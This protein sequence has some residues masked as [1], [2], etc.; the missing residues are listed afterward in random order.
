MEIRRWR[1]QSVFARYA[2]VSQQEIR[3]AVR[4]LETSE[5][6]HIIVLFGEHGDSYCWWRVV[7][8]PPLLIEGS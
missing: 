5:I 4:K 7:W 3:D 2:I 1:A 8:R 6:G